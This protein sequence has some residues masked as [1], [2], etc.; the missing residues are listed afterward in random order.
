MS[1]EIENMFF[2]GQ[3]PWHG[4]GQQVSPDLTS[5]AAISA[6][7]LD[8]RVEM[9]PLYVGVKPDQ[10][11]PEHWLP[12]VLQV[13][14][15][16]TVRA[17]D[18]SVLG[19]VGADYEPLQNVDAFG[20][21]DDYIKAGLACYHTAGSLRGGARVWILAQIKADPMDIVPGD[22]VRKFILLSNGHDGTMAVRVGFTPIRVVCANTLAIAHANRQS[23]LIKVRHTGNVAEDVAALRDV[24]NLA[25]QEFEATA[26]QYRALA[27]RQ[28]SSADLAAYVRLVFGKQKVT[29]A[30][31]PAQD[32]EPETRKPAEH[33]IILGRVTEMFEKGRGNDAPGVRGTLWAA[34]NAATEYLAYGRGKAADAR[35]NSLWFGE[36]ANINRR[37]LATA[38]RMAVDLES[39]AEAETAPASPPARQPDADDGNGGDDPYQDT[40]PMDDPSG[41]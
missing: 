11:F 5:E 21:F 38:I 34:Y 36:A 10:K 27:R 41:E 22:A 26:E 6:A 2:V 1:H 35:L 15:R 31:G 29:D 8:W 20:F 28:I 3:T 13:P 33:K 39:D 24:M 25:N 12:K 40:D 7:G 14:A 19:V 16:A 32:E 37:A 9:Q 4:L 18:G 17:T 30:E 23:A